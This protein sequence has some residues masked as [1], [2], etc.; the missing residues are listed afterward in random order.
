MT[1]EEELSRV[2]FNAPALVAWNGEQ[3]AIA[4]AVHAAGY[5]KAVTVTEFGTIFNRTVIFLNPPAESLDVFKERYEREFGWMLRE[6]DPIL[7]RTFLRC[8][9]EP[10]EPVLHAGIAQ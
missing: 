4:N 5:R 2:I 7:T 6:R 8:D 10:G 1:S 3:R 9:P